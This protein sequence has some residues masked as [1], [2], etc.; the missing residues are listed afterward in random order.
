[1][2]V[3]VLGSIGATVARTDWASWTRGLPASLQGQADALQPLVVLGR[4][5]QVQTLAS[6]AGGPAGGAAAAQQAV[7]AFTNGMGQ[8]FVIG[9]GVALV[10]GALA[11]VGLAFHREPATG[12]ISALEIADP[13]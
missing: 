10:A 9:A 6:Q 4:G 5:S 13:R 7:T 8:A 11:V 1:L 3:A 2:G 12:P